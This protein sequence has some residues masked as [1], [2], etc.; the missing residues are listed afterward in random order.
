MKQVAIITIILV[1]SSLAWGQCAVQQLPEDG[2]IQESNPGN[3]D[4]P[5]PPPL[6][7]MEAV[8]LDKPEKC[9]HC[10]EGWAQGG[11]IIWMEDWQ[12]WVPGG[13][14]EMNIQDRKVTDINV[15]YW[16][17]LYGSLYPQEWSVRGTDT[18]L[19]YPVV[20]PIPL[21]S[22]GQ[23]TNHG[24]LFTLTSE[25]DPSNSCN[26]TLD[27]TLTG[28]T[29]NAWS[30]DML[31]TMD[32]SGYWEVFSGTNRP[33]KGM[34]GITG[35]GGLLPNWDLRNSPDPVRSGNVDPESHYVAP[36]PLPGPGWY[37]GGYSTWTENGNDWVPGGWIEMN[38]QN[39]QITDMTSYYWLCP[40][41]SCFLWGWIL[42]SE[43][44]G[45]E[46]DVIEPIP[47]PSPGEASSHVTTFTIPYH[48]DPEN[49]CEAQLTWTFTGLDS[50]GWSFEMLEYLF[51]PSDPGILLIIDMPRTGAFGFSGQPLIRD[52]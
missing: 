11:I 13:W 6:I 5:K 42:S 41:S 43:S 37:Q 45:M 27:W 22:I 16:I 34:I 25:T 24:M 36:G 31:E 30:F 28:V 17:L 46:D 20:D 12:E 40:S 21:P 2:R 1:L 9:I 4:I 14:I 48:A 49:P 23:T 52:Y 3:L 32:C 18:G 47:L 51:C 10:L 33:R 26:F 44:T 35:E 50:G 15:Y 38:I 7:S 29:V 39:Q 19:G 8:Y